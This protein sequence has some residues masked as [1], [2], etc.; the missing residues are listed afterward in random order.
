MKQILV[1]GAGQSASFLI[2]QLL[3]DAESEDWFVTV[4]DLDLELARARV[5][6]APAGRARCASTSTTP[7]CA[8][9]RSSTPTS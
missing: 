1:L 3:E 7:G 2:A 5:G 4:G 6:D 8:R 9:R